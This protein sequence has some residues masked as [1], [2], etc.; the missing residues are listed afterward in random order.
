MNRTLVVL[1]SVFLTFLLVIANNTYAN[2][3]LKQFDTPQQEN[4]YRDLIAELRCLVC[5]NQNL[6]DSNAELA[7]DLR[8][9]T[10]EMVSSGSSKQDVIDYMV[11]RYGEFVLYRPPFNLST[12]FLWVGPFIF[13]GA[14]ILI[15]LK[16]ISARKK[17]PPVELDKSEQ[18]KVQALLDD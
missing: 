15:L 3:D 7:V 12:I 9:Q 6:A 11:T 16:I 5:Q 8:R 1:F 18:E 13:L 2:I 14:S 17:E 10:Y 4:D